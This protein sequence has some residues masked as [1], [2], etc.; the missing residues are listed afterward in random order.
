[1]DALLSP[2]TCSC[3]N[4]DP[5]AEWVRVG[6]ELDIARAPQLERTLD[7]CQA[8]LVVVDLRELTFI[9]SSGLHAIINA[10]IR[11]R[12]SGRRLVLVRVPSDVERILTLTGIS[13]HVEIADADPVTPPVHA[14]QRSLVAQSLLLA[15]TTPRDRAPAE[16]PAP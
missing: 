8:R 12:R 5:R 7:A 9:D 1:V 14:L 16:R 4:G 15:A 2:F 10:G 6:G 13:D 3:T 11:A